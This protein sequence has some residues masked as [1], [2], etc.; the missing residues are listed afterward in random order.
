MEVGRECLTEISCIVPPAFDEPAYQALGLTKPSAQFMP[1][2][3]KTA[4][5]SP[6]RITHES[7]ALRSSS[8]HQLSTN[9]PSRLTVHSALNIRLSVQ[10]FCASRRH[11]ILPACGCGACF[12]LSLQ[13]ASAHLSAL[14]LSKRVSF[15]FYSCAL[16]V[17]RPATTIQ[18]HLR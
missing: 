10:S 7:L 15:T 6:Y 17:Q 4:I 13:Q 14:P 18:L 5:L 2:W 9:L 3:L 11:T 12:E 16:V 1:H 8:S